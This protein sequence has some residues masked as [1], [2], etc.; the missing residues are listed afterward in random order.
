[1]T[2]ETS[3]DNFSNEIEDRLEHLF[4]EEEP[5]E[6]TEISSGETKDYPL[7]DLKTIIL[8]ID[9]EINEE[10]M[11]GFVEQIGVL[12][13]K[14][15][16]D[17]IVLVFLQLL[18]SIGEYIRKNLGQSHPEAFRILNSLFSGLEK[19]VQEDG[20]DDNEKKRIL[21]VELNKYKQL[22]GQLTPTKAPPAKKAAIGETSS[23]PKA[24]AIPHDLHDA[25]E[26][27]KLFFQKELDAL[28][29]EISALRRELSKGGDNSEG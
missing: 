19:V 1:L 28:K 9:W 23:A 8:S 25:I 16:D 2:I 5:A 17:K 27:L 22:K 20:L 18:G 10:V 13:D 26:D 3:E 29:E 12:Q 4:G 11:S 21:S 15:Q 7:R 14:Y 6:M 24:E